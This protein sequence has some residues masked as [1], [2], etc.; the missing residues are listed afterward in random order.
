M[1]DKI[2]LIANDPQRKRIKIDEMCVISKFL[3]QHLLPLKAELSQED[4]AVANNVC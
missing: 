4:I 1:V 2:Y 3:D